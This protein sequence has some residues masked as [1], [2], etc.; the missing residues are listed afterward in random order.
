MNNTL[1]PLRGEL[2]GSSTCSAA[3]ITTRSPAPVSAL[4]RALQAAG[5]NADHALECYRG[6]TLALRV[7]SI[8]GARLTV[9]DNRLGRPVFASWRDRP[10]SDGAGPSIAATML[11]GATL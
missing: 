2:T 9:Q 11:D 7:R 10:A 3:G 1:K 4:C 8:Q 6:D 5:L